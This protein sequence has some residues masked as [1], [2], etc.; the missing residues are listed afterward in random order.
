MKIWSTPDSETLKWESWVLQ[1]LQ[2]YFQ[3]MKIWST[4]DFATLLAKNENLEYSRFE[5]LLKE[6]LNLEY[7]RFWEKSKSGVLQILYFF[8][9]KRKIWS[10]SN[11][12]FSM[13]TQILVT[14]D[15]VKHFK[16]GVLQI[17]NFPKGKSKSGVLQIL[18]FA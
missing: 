5:I 7:S 4:P 12:I 13:L 9:W 8:F 6:N 2:L 15:F 14:P 10:K 16:S 1:I 11:W 17:W 18:H 3:K